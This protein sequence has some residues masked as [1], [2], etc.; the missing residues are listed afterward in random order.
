M[1]FTYSNSAFCRQKLVCYKLLLNSPT[2][3]SFD[4]WKEEGDRIQMIN[5][6]YRSS[7]TIEPANGQIPSGPPML[8]VMYNNNYQIVQN[9]DYVMIMAE[10]NHDGS[11][12][13]CLKPDGSRTLKKA[14][15][16]VDGSLV[17]R[18]IRRS[19]P[20]IYTLRPDGLLASFTRW[21]LSHAT[22]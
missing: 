5:S 6:E 14:G 18:H 22:G 16:F 8:P 19:I 3:S 11:P 10:M 20:G 17:C 12:C 21:R 9:D 1:P 7:I 4:T 15:L 13:N 2:Q